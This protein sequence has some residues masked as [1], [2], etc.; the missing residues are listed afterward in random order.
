MKLMRTAIHL[1]LGVLLWLVF[2]FYWH[3]VMQQPVTGETRRALII[4]GAVVAAITIFDLFW[5]FHNQR[6]ARRSRRRG[7]REAAPQPSFD[8]LGRMFVAQ[9]D[10]QLRRARYIEVHVVQMEDD[11]A[12]MGRKLFRVTD[13]VPEK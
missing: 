5:I 6:I 2:V 4:V 8:F 3:L 9:S 12:A 7:R 13:E 10:E 11:E 1:I